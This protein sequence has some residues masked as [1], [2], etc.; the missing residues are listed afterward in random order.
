M[1]VLSAFCGGTRTRGSAPLASA[2]NRGGS[3]RPLSSIADRSARL[4]ARQVPGKKSFSCWCSKATFQNHTRASPPL[5]GAQWLK[6]HFAMCPVFLRIQHVDNP[7]LSTSHPLL[8]FCDVLLTKGTVQVCEVPPHG[9]LYHQYNQSYPQV[10][11]EYVPHVL[12]EYV[13]TSQ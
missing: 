12:I 4:C 2:L 8:A 3:F 10:L 13:S 5:L 1:S 7:I 6:V 9:V 11:N